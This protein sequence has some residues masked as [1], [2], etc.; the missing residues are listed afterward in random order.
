MFDGDVVFALSLVGSTQEIDV[1]IAG[2]VAARM[3]TEAI[4]QAV[5]SAN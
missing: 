4:L 2:S 5:R 3:V 1:N